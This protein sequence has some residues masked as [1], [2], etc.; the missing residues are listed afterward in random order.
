MTERFVDGL[1]CRLDVL[2]AQCQ[3]GEIALHDVSRLQVV[4]R[5]HTPIDRLSLSK[6]IATHQTAPQHLERA[7]KDMIGRASLCLSG[8]AQCRRVVLH[9]PM[10]VGEAGERLA[11]EFRAKRITKR[12]G[13][14]MSPMRIGQSL[15]E[16]RI[17]V[18][19]QL[20]RVRTY[21]IKD[22][23][24]V[25][26][27]VGMALV[28]GECLLA[29]IECPFGIAPRERLGQS[30]LREVERVEVALGMSLRDRFIEQLLAHA[31]AVGRES[32]KGLLVECLSRPRLV[33]RSTAATC[34]NQHR[35][36]QEE[37]GVDGSHAIS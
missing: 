22:D 25:A 29:H 11:E 1:L 9:R 13:Q 24:V 23:D 26:L 4:A 35:Q 5:T 17:V 6:G 2:T 10:D 27:A 37:V 19:S 28:G 30:Q 3:L 7:L 34:H 32:T 20:A 21:I 31:Y 36:E 16:G 12:D 18:V 33:G 15:V 8:K 14:G